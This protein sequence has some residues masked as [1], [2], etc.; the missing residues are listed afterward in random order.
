MHSR[1]ILAISTV[2]TL[3]YQLRLT[4]V[5]LETTKAMLYFKILMKTELF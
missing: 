1:E 3:Q 5:P 4:I 2:E